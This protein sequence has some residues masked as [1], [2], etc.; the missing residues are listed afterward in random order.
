MKHR[1]SFLKFALVLTGAF[2]GSLS[3][4]AA[5]DSSPEISFAVHKLSEVNIEGPNV[6]RTY[7]TIGTK[8]MIFGLPKDCRLA[9]EDGFLLLP[10]ETAGFDG[11]VH[12]T[13]STFTPETDLA[14]EALRYREAAASSM[15]EGSTNIQVQPPVL[16][17]YPFNGWKSLGFTWTYS[18]FGRPMVRTVSYINLD[19]GVQVVVTT[20]AAKSDAAVVDKVAKGFISSWWVMDD[21]RVK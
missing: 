5:T 12:V 6:E 13:R 3:H 2:G 15:P 10:T 11:E 16:N 14:A 4:A 21:S 8:R 19:G 9:V 17:P 7:F 20:I 1:I 18:S